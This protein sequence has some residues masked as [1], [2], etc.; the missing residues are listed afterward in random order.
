MRSFWARAAGDVEVKKQLVVA[1]LIASF[2]TLFETLLFFLLV[3]PRAAET[4]KGMLQR[5]SAVLADDPVQQDALRAVLGTADAME[6]E[7]VQQNHETAAFTAVLLI[8]LP[9]LVVGFVTA[10]S[11]TFRAAPKRD[12]VVDTVVVV[13][14]ILFFQGAFYFLGN[15]WGYPGQPEMLVD[16]G[17]AYRAAAGPGANM[18]TDCS[19]CAELL[20]SR[21]SKSPTMD[22]L[23]AKMDDPEARNR[24]LRDV[25]LGVTGVSV[26]VDVG[27]AR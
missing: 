9:L 4:I 19:G 17:E 1:F 21:L 24:L 16:I 10:S 5:D 14:G 3:M 26:G 8:L 6:R 25:F 12:M 22:K 15:Q 20:R 27:V 2:V 23:G 7:Y 11:P 13:V 18:M